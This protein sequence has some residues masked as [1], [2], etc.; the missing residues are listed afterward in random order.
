MTRSPPYAV[1]QRYECL[2]YDGRYDGHHIPTRLE[3]GEVSGFR[4][5]RVLLY[6]RLTRFSCRFGPKGVIDPST[7]FTRLTLDAITL[8][9]MSYRYV[10]AA[11]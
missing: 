1:L 4:P 7:D 11:M 5:T 3:V 6:M 9:A 8:C 2:Q 10:L